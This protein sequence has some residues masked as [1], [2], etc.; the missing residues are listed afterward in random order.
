MAKKQSEEK[1]PK[2][3]APKPSSDPAEPT[4]VDPGPV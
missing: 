2:K 1:K 4:I 3:P